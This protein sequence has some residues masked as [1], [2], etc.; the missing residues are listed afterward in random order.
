MKKPKKKEAVHVRGIKWLARRSHIEL[1]DDGPG[2]LEETDTS[3][4]TPLIE[5]PSSELIAANTQFETWK[6]VDPFPEIAPSLLNAADIDDYARTTA[7]VYPYDANKRKT[8]SY[9]L[10]VGNE[11]AFWDPDEPDK[12]PLRS[13]NDGSA[14]VI[15]SNSLIYVRTAELFQLPNYMAVRFNLHIDLVH[16]GLLL[17]TGPL[18]DPGFSGRLM[19]PLH[20]LTSNTYILQVGEDF[21]WAEFTKTSLVDRWTASGAN[22]PERS[23]Q[24]VKFPERKLNKSLADY[25]ASARK[26]HDVFQRGMS[27]QSLQNAIPDA[28]ARTG[29]KASDAKR[30][31]KKASNKVTLLTGIGILGIF[32]AAATMVSQLLSTRSAL[33]STLTLVGTTTS[34]IVDQGKDIQQLQSDLHRAEDE[35][36]VIKAREEKSQNGVPS[37][38]G[39]R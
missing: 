32:G 4:A 2:A 3:P 10:S 24:L 30:S 38:R 20:N 23:G 15:P 16:K 29:R 33:Q 19:V 35:L 17:G 14:V 18:V 27:Y 11:I 26:G 22:R 1:A 28:I 36:N 31:A 21:I 7:M 8:A 12:S 34:K 6:D 13:L 37:R 5:A 39:L 9:P 25:L